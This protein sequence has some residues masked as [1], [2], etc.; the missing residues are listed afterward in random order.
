[1]ADLIVLVLIFGALA[2]VHFAITRWSVNN[3][4]DVDPSFVPPRVY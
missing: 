2:L 1:M 3:D 4:A